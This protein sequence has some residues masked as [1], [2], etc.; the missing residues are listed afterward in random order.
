MSHWI[1]KLSEMLNRLPRQVVRTRLTADTSGRYT[2]VVDAFRKV[3]AC[4]G[5]SW[6]YCCSFDF[7]LLC[8]HGPLTSHRGSPGTAQVSAAEGVS[9]M[10]RGLLP[11]A[12]AMLPE[13]AITYGGAP[14]TSCAEPFAQQ[15]LHEHAD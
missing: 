9:G 5:V 3:G 10:Y 6:A 1:Q 7:S 12:I 14:A 15:L 4:E 11:S 13:A 8:L 2:G